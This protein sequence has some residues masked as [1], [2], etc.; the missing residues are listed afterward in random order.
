[1]SK[2]ELHGDNFGNFGKNNT[3]ENMTVGA[4][5]PTVKIGESELSRENLVAELR[6]LRE[7]WGILDDQDAGEAVLAIESAEEAL[8][9][10]RDDAAV[11]SLQKAGNWAVNAATSIGTGV[12]SAAVAAALGLL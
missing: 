9:N 3:V 2:Y 8:R 1:M 7:S 4:A 6:A 11:K 12:A 10:G 5:A